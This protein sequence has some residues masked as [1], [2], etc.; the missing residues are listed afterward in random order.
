[1][2]RWPAL[3][4]RPLLAG[5]SDP[6]GLTRLVD[7]PAFDP[8]ALDPPA[9]DPPALDPP[10]LD[11]PQPVTTPYCGIVAVTWNPAQYQR[12]SG[13]R[14]R[15]FWDLVARV[16]VERPRRILD[17][18]C[19]T[20]DLTAA[21]A[22]QWPSAEVVGIDSS[23]EMIRACT[24]G[25]RLRFERAEIQSRTIDGDVDLVFS[26]AALHW[27]PAHRQLLVAWADALPSG[28]T[29]AWQVPGNFHAPSHQLLQQLAASPQWASRLS[30]VLR[31]DD[32]V[33]SPA[34]YAALLLA[35]GWTADAWE[36]TYVHV[37][38]GP[39]AVLEWVRG[40]TLGPVRSVL[41]EPDYADFEQEYAEM[42]GQA[43]PGRSF[44]TIFPFRRVFA[45]GHKP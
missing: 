15:P 13:E 25:A 5:S 29:M 6:P 27:V 31:F 2:P 4:G 12:F 21:L 10:A 14:A 28:A 26:N 36:T 24:P 17:L 16:Q 32:P 38:P 20:G 33:G 43:Y 41:S 39:D 37:L 7:P 23:A 45:V 8:P 19:G 42:L 30:G 35:A 22:A 9:L 3:V 44:G 11:P 40:T 34:D 1:M 18:G